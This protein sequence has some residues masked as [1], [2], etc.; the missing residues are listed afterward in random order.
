MKKLK[1]VGAVALKSAHKEKGITLVALIITIIVM[2]ILV[3]VSVQVVVNSDLIGT[4][5]DAAD[6][7]ENAYGE[8]GNISEIKIGNETY[9]SV[10]EYIYGPLIK[11]SIMGIECKVPEGWT[12][13]QFVGSEFDTGEYGLLTFTSSDF[14]LLMVDGELLRSDSF[15]TI[16]PDFLISNGGVYNTNYEYTPAG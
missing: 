13:R 6:R 1:N 2:L 8:E 3:G 15:Y 11:F 16:Q 12:W 5:Q 10:D 14:P 4:A 7:T 9:S